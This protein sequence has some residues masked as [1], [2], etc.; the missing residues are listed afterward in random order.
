MSVFGV[1]V[2]LVGLSVS[3]LKSIALVGDMTSSAV[4]V[5]S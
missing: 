4:A 2:A 1:I 5:V 3:W